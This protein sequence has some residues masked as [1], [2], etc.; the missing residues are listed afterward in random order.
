MLATLL[1]LKLKGQAGGGVLVF[2]TLCCVIGALT[3]QY[4]NRAWLL[5]LGTW[6]FAPGL[7]LMRKIH[8]TKLGAN[9]QA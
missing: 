7:G 1:G 4:M 3:L 8:G 2:C 9:G 5:A 6:I